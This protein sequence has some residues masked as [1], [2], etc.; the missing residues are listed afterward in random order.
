M[1]TTGGPE[2]ADLLRLAPVGA[3]AGVLRAWSV[4][5][6]ALGLG[7]LRVVLRRVV[8]GLAAGVPSTAGRCVG[9]RRSGRSDQQSCRQRGPDERL[10]HLVC[11]PQGGHT[12]E[13]TRWPPHPPPDPCTQSGTIRTLR[14]RSPS[15]PGETGRVAP[16]R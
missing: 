3:G 6:P 8:H 9:E 16:D 10:L 2:L 14:Y 4:N 15:L 7:E 1:G 5:I 13:A 12:N 11:L